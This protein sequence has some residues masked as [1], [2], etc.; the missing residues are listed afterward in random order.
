MQFTLFNFY[1]HRKIPTF[2]EIER[3]NLIFVNVH[4]VCE[5]TFE[6]YFVHKLYDYKKLFNHV[7]ILVFEMRTGPQFLR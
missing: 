2:F 6:G 1:D 3:P 7:K 4:T 5:K